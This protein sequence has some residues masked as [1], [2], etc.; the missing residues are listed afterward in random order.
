V[1]QL[2]VALRP[3]WS[4]SSFLAYAGALTVLLALLAL[5]GDLGNRHGSWALAGWAALAL[6]VL[7]G[8]TVRF[9][10][11]GRPLEAGLAAF[12]AVGA[13]GVLAGAVLRGIGLADGTA[14]FDDDFE[15]A[16]LLIELAVLAAALFAARRLR[17]PLLMLAATVAQVVLVLDLVT[18]IVGGGNWL[19][20]A[21]LLLGLVELGI[22]RSLDGE[23]GRRPWA[24][25]KHVA[26]ALLI[27][28]SAVTLLDSGDV[29]WVVIALLALAFVGLA[30]AFDRSVWAVVGAFGLFLV[31]THFVDGASTLAETVPLVPI[32]TDGDGLELWQTSLLYLG[33]GAVLVLLAR[34]VRQ[35]TVR[36][37]EST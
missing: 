20:W 24:F 32:Q 17:F 37:G 34:W 7:A 23:A 15:L 36:A 26:A 25:W 19:Q 22:A 3:T 33:L 4:S 35:P 30:R 5:L 1:S 28:T 31:T 10:R 9:E 2:P 29:G 6:A 21:A 14:P 12:V 16:P 27:G 18:G 8:L 13:V 11:E